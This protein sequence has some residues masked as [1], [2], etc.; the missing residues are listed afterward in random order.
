MYFPAF[1]SPFLKMTTVYYADESVRLMKALRSD[2]AEFMKRCLERVKQEVDR[3]K[4]MFIEESWEKVRTACEMALFEPSHS[5]VARDGMFCQSVTSVILTPVLLA[6]P[7]LMDN[8]DLEKLGEVYT[9]FTRV[10]CAGEVL[11]S[12]KH[13]IHV[14]QAVACLLVLRH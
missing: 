1:E 7:K 3:A 6:L 4:E 2:P 13:Y 9:T 8:E 12:F 10:K 5:W 11:L 14:S